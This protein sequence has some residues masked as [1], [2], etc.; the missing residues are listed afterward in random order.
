MNE[1]LSEQINLPVIRAA[2]TGIS[3][4]AFPDGRESLTTPWHQEAVL[5]AEIT[6]FET[7]PTLFQKLGFLSTFGFATFLLMIH[8]LLNFLKRKG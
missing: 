8:F 4:I 3:G 7:R 1:F 6:Y 2:N 5:N